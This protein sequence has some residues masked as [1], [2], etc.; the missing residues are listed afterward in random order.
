MFL[1]VEVLGLN[2]AGVIDCTQIP[3][4]APWTNPEQYL[5]RNRIFAINT[6]LVV[7]HRGMITY[8]SA[9]WPGSV[10]DSHVLQESY[11]QDVLDEH[12]LGAYYL[13]GKYFMH[14]LKYN[15]IQD[16]MLPRSYDML[17]SHDLRF[18]SCL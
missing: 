10:H 5:N 4:A 6:Q 18:V 13:T 17:S 16:P 3:I 7:N 2:V 15:S 1:F 12:L 14:N 11:L 8:L 9:C